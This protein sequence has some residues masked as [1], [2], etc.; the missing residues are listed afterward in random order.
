MLN[1]VTDELECQLSGLLKALR[2]PEVGSQIPDVFR[3]MRMKA[4]L[5]PPTEPPR[6]SGITDDSTPV[7]FSVQFRAVSSDLRILFE[8]QADPATPASYW[9]S[10]C[11]MTRWLENRWNAQ[12]GRALEVEGLFRPGNLGKV[13]LAGG[14]AVAFRDGRPTF[15]VYYNAMAKGFDTGKRTAAE[16]L[17]RLGFKTS[18]S[19]L[20]R[21]LLPQDRI[22]IIAIDLAETPRIKIYVRPLQADLP[23]LMRLSAMS[24]NSDPALLKQ[25]WQTIHPG[26]KP[27]KMRPT[28]LTFELTEKSRTAASAVTFSIPLFPGVRSDEEARTRISDLMKEVGISPKDYRRCVDAMAQLPL[29]EEE[30]IHSYVSLHG[31]ARGVSIVTY[32]N[33]RLYLRKYGWLARNPS[34]TWPSPVRTTE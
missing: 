10:A 33:P 31:E 21:I 27:E 1:K 18:W 22:D 3:E 6:W 13:Y 23:H 2:I 4:N 15:K 24:A 17:E 25:A 19:S 26:C 34:R 32:F 12:I 29:C 30:G 9:R 8:P 28:F 16:A 11:R 5:R 7:E 20:E 14:H